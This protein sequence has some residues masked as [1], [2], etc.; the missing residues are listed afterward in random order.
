M[1]IM[2]PYSCPFPFLI[3]GCVGLYS[4]GDRQEQ[5]GGRGPRGGIGMGSGGWGSLIEAWCPGKE[6]MGRAFF[7]GGTY[8]FH[9][10]LFSTQ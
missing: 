10:S 5:P 8:I 2:F 7:G 3:T 1:L 6:V 4:T 9:H